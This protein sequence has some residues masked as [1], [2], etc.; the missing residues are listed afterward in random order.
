MD[1]GNILNINPEC[2]RIVREEAIKIEIATIK[3]TAVVIEKILLGSNI[4]RYYPGFREWFEKVKRENRDVIL[5]TNSCELIG[6]AILKHTKDYTKIC[7]LFILEE[8]R[9]NG[10]C[11][12]LFDYAIKSYRVLKFSVP[13]EINNIYDKIVSSYEYN[14]LNLEVHKNIKNSNEKS[15]LIKRI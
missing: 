13:E 3:G 7:S 6:F 4:E 14:F 5:L 12:L 9:L 15:Y 10:Y 8:Y 2:I 11:K 1:K